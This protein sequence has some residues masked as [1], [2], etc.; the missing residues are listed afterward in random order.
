M[1]QPLQPLGGKVA[2]VTGGAAGIGRAIAVGLAA[3]GAEVIVFD[4]SE[5]AQSVAEI[6]GNGHKARAVTGNVAIEP[7]VLE[8]FRGIQR[9]ERRLDIAVNCAG[10]QLIRPLLETTAEDFD[11][12]ISVNLKGTFLVGREAARMMQEQPPGARIINIASELAYLGRAKYSVY[13]ASKGGILSLTRAWAREL[14]PHILVNAV[15]PGPTDTAM[16]SLECM[17]PSEIEQE[18]QGVPLGRIAKPAEIASAVC[19]L[20]GSGASFMTGQ[21]IS[22]N[23]G[24][25]M[26]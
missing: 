11:H 6:I 13:C 20:A 14:A 7:D 3:D 8:L 21:C 17:T 16:V 19:F 26:F 5:S 15:A 12:V 23:G 25:V 2:L 9:Q 10:I 24:A 22:P 18:I 1:S 4:R